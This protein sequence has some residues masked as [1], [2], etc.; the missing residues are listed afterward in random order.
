MAHFKDSFKDLHPFEKRKNDAKQIKSI[1]P[2]RI[3]II[4]EKNNYSRNIPDIDKKKY[5]IPNNLTLGEFVSV[6]RKRIKLE[7]GV[8]LYFFINGFIFSNSHFVSN[9]YAEYKDEDGFLYIY[10]ATENTFGNI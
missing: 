10:Y 9:L 5:L 8:A 3:P 4:C 7:P 6:I 2:N 1:Y